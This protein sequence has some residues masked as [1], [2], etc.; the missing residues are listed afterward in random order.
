MDDSKDWVQVRKADLDIIDHL[1]EKVR[2]SVTKMTCGDLVRLL[3]LRK[4]MLQEEELDQIRE[5]HVTW[6]SEPET[7]E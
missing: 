2:D 7:D 5:V 1:I 4:E 6:E 3:Q